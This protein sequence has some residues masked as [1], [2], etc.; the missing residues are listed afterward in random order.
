VRSRGWIASQGSDRFPDGREQVYNLIEVVAHRLDHGTALTIGVQ[1][2]RL[3]FF[4]SQF[5][6]RA[7]SQQASG[8]EPPDAVIEFG[9]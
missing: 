7:V 2:D 8:L 5:G 1:F 6:E 3:A 4:P 9:F